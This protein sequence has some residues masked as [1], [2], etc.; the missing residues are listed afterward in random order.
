MLAETL[1]EAKY[2]DPPGTGSTCLPVALKW[3]QKSSLHPVT[4]EI[5]QLWWMNADLARSARGAA[6]EVIAFCPEG[7]MKQ[8]L[9][10][11]CL[12]FVDK[13]IQARPSVGKPISARI[14]PAQQ[15]KDISPVVYPLF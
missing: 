10:A 1:L 12:P 8:H 9:V 3:M 11:I 4:S 5:T 7:E 15:F 13:A 2:L 6:E 14:C